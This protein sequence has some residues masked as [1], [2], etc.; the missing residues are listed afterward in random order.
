MLCAVRTARTRRSPAIA[1]VP[2]IAL[3]ARSSQA[4][5]W[6][7]Q[8][9]SELLDVPYFHVVFT[10]PGRIAAIAYQNSVAVYD[11]LFKASS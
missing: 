8:R 9:K 2:G 10:L 3:G 7:K 6:M 1:A 11:L 5:A 4:L